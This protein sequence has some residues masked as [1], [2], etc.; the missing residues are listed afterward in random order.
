M[1][2]PVPVASAA[3]VR[4]NESPP[5]VAALSKRSRACS[6]KEACWFTAPPVSPVP[7]R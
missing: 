5:T 7:L 6:M 2:P 4:R 1:V 3:P